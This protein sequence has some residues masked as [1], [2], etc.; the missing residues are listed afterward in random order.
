MASVPV[1]CVF[2]FFFTGVFITGCAKSPEAE[3]PAGVLFAEGNEA[4]ENRKFE[5]AIAAYSRLKD[6]Y[7]FSPH[8]ITAE[9]KIA[10]ARFE[11]ES[12]GEAAAAYDSFVR[13]HPTNPET[14]YALYRSGVCYL[15]QMDTPDRD[16][17]PTEQALAIFNLV[18]QRYP[19]SAYARQAEDHI[20][21]CFKSLTDHDFYVGEFY[22]RT[23]EYKAAW[24]RFEHLVTRYPDVG[25]HR[26]ALFYMRLC[27][28]KIKKQ[29]AEQARTE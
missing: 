11:M 20:R 10:D 15:K 18:V 17:G 19:D 25:S 9:L 1:F 5:N 12:Y 23:R 8:A 28:E 24:K 26:A 6:W 13:L 22:Y 4:Y 14:P 27:E 16:Q 3:K 29:E 7:P 2:V 21:T